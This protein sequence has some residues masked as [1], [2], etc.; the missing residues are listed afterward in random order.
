MSAAEASIEV[1]EYTPAVIKQAV[2]GNGQ[3]TKDQV[4]HMV[5]LLLG[6]GE[7]SGFDAADALA[8]AICHINHQGPMSRA[9]G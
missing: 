2:V 3:A 6:T 5:K 1:F 7:I 9:P 4:E 8:T